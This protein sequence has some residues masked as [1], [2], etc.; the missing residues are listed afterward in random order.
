[1]QLLDAREL[2]MKMRKSLGE[3]RKQVSEEQI[4]EITRLYGAFEESERVKVFPNEAFGY[5]RI[6]VERPLRPRWSGEACA[7]GSRPP[8]ASRSSTTTL[9]PSF[10]R[11][12][13]PGS[14]GSRRDR[15]HRG[16]ERK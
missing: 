13:R 3:K 2:W 8:G 15:S 12:R 5:Q 4:A 6:T 9:A 11:R 7:S 14:R 10:S 1:V 16:E